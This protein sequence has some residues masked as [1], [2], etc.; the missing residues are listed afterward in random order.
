M[1]ASRAGGEDVSR[2][3]SPAA[4]DTANLKGADILYAYDIADGSFTD[5]SSHYTDVFD[6]LGYTYEIVS[7]PPNSPIDWPSPFTTA[8]YSL[9]I[10]NTSENWWDAPNNYQAE[11]TTALLGYCGTATAGAPGG[12]YISGQDLIW[13]YAPGWGTPNDGLFDVYAGVSSVTQD[14]YWDVSPVTWT[15]AGIL[16]GFSGTADA[17]SVFTATDNLFF[18]DGLTPSTKGEVI[19]TSDDGTGPYDNGVLNETADVKTIFTTLELAADSSN[20][21]AALEAILDWYFAGSAIKS[22]SL[23]EIKASFK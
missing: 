12:L 3:V 18:C 21:D 6:A 7:A 9:V 10:V 15:G 19:I 2:A 5:V 22:A 1:T 8:D 14:V 17:A 23:G 11:D 20:F 13:G 16:S 4:P